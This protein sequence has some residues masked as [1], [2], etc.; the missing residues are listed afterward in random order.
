MN[1]ELGNEISK[2]HK[3]YFELCGQFVSPIKKALSVELHNGTINS[4][5]NNLW[6]LV[7][8]DNKNLL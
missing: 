8:C 2:S 3:S 5:E 7:V 1:F 6:D 4:N